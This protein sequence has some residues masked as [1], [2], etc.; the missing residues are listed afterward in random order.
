MSRPL[1]LD[2]FSG[3]G[4]AA[5]GYHRAGFHVTGVD[6]A[7]QPRYCGDTFI[8]GDALEYLAAHGHEYDVI[9]ASPECQGYSHL[10]PHKYRQNHP[11]QIADV[12][13]LLKS[14]AKPYI[15]ENVRGARKHLHSPVMLCGSMFGLPIFRHRY[16]EIGGFETLLAP[17]CCHNF[18]PIPINS[19]SAQRTANKA[20]CS[21]GLQ[22][23]WMIRAELRQAIPPAYTEWI[24]RQL[25]WH[26]QGRA[27]SA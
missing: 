23:D 4:G 1:L 19:S 3:A 27:V 15:I 24:G 7:P 18:R 25:M 9:H 2:L 13:A 17:P 5:M 14:L 16:F 21:E 20:E 12:R 6:I 10:T 11:L 26:L 22:I 8:Q